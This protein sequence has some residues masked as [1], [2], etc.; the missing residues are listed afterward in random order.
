MLA[1]ILIHL[2]LEHLYLISV[3]NYHL[4]CTGKSMAASVKK[5]I[6]VDF[7]HLSLCTILRI[8]LSTVCCV[9]DG[10]FLEFKTLFVDRCG[11]CSG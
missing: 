3:E 4:Y 9:C 8:Y 7:V 6:P 11:C 5:D 1:L 2:S 10:Y